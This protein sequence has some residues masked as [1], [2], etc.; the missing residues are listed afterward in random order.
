M[1]P[2]SAHTFISAPR[3]EVFDLLVDMAA[4]VAFA[5]HFLDHFRLTSPRS[6]GVGAGA[7]FQLDMPFNKTWAETVIVEADRPRRLVE[8]GRTGR[9][10]RNATTTVYELTPQAGGV[11]RVE[12]TFAS[13][14]AHPAERLR[15]SL[16]ARRWM[17][18][19]QRKA[20]ERLRRLLEEPP[21]QPLPRATIAGWE[22]LKAPRFG[23]PPFGA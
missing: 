17:R 13:E 15:E 2:V 16:G 4:R 1:V 22:A 3:E 20:L 11:T 19:Q 23:A 6:S 21:E 9:L 18:R 14:P 7:R 8:H 12:V 10:G 5:D